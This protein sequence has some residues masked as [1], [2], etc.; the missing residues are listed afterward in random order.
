MYVEYTYNNNLNFVITETNTG[1]MQNNNHIPTIYIGKPNKQIKKNKSVG[2]SSCK[3]N[4]N[5]TYLNLHQ[6]ELY[7]STS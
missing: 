6:V 7:C 2:F 5:T 1:L 4:T 3:I